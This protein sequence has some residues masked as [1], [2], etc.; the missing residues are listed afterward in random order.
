MIE[1]IS[2]LGGGFVYMVTR[3]GVTGIRTDISS[4]TCCL[5]R[6]LIQRVKKKTELPVAVGFGI[7]NSLQAAEII[8][9]G[10]NGVIVGSAFVDI[11][12]RGGD[13]SRNLETLARDLKKGI[14][15]GQ[16]SLQERSYQIPLMP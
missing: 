9:S 16:V 6:E 1:I 11:I 14:R 2:S 7:S 12:S 10:A 8:G 15:A 13:V 3:P 4:L 5:T